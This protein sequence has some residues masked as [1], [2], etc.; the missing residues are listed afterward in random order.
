LG[1]AQWRKKCREPTIYG[2]C[3]MQMGYVLE[4]D[5]VVNPTHLL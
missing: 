5:T 2:R 1:K 3:N 4:N